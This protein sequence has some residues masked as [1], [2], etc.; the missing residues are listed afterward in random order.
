MHI[1]LFQFLSPRVTHWLALLFLAASIGGGAVVAGG[2]AAAFADDTKSSKV[3]SA[4]PAQVNINTAGPAELA[5]ALKGVGLRKARAI[6]SYREKFG[7]FVS[8]DQLAEVK[9]IG[10]RTVERN[11]AAIRIK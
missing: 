8:V 5:A 9:G 6:I 4:L 7:E 10:A 2:S 3:T 1:S 11:R